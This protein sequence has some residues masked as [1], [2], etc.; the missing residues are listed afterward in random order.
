[1]TLLALAGGAAAAA[2]S[3]H[4]VPA[5]KSLCLSCHDPHAALYARLLRFPDDDQACWACHGSPGAPFARADYEQSR[6]FLG[7]GGEPGPAVAGQAPAEDEA[8]AQPVLQAKTPTCIRCHQPHGRV[9]APQLLRPSPAAD[10]RDGAVNAAC[11]ACH[12]DQVKTHSR[13]SFGGLAVYRRTRH[14]DP[15]R[16]AAKAGAKADVP[17]QCTAC[18][19]PHGSRYAS[20]LLT[21]P[22]TACYG[23][24]PKPT[25]P[26]NKWTGD[27]VFRRSAHAEVCLDCHNPHGVA[28]PVSG[29][30]YPKALTAAETELCLR[31]HPSVAGRFAESKKASAVSGVRSRHPVDEA[32]AKVRCVSCHNPHQVRQNPPGGY[33]AALTDPNSG[34]LFM[35]L[36]GKTSQEYCLK[37]HDGSWPGAADITAEMKEKQA[38]VSGFVWAGKATNLHNLHL[39][40]Y[41]KQQCSSCHDPHATAGS[42][43]INRGH[44]LRNLTVTAYQPGQ[45]YP[46]FDSCQTECH[47]ARCAS[48]HPAPPEWVRP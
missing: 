27:K 15:Q 45:G 38:A 8:A 1:M 46:G 28:D 47:H 37:C 13:P 39:V 31:C 24:H 32:N 7:L 12:P 26:K 35:W 44:L 40:R 22:K 4:G 3:P 19:Q 2:D 18:H 42:A 34:K 6:H 43:G 14:A 23:C 20:L 41:H 10:K 5:Q 21:E 33:E 17:G 36:S 16:G 29:A 9:A 30:V 25:D 11:A 48:C